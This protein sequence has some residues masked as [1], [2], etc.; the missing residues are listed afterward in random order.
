[1]L[2]KSMNFWRMNTNLSLA[3]SQHFVASSHGRWL[4]E[5]TIAISV[6]VLSS[7]PN[8]F[9]LLHIVRKY[10]RLYILTVGTEHTEKHHSE[11]QMKIEEY[12]SINRQ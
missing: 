10:K 2:E 4:S 11:H 3:V 8:G 1:M 5:L 9:S 6:V 7:V 12:Y